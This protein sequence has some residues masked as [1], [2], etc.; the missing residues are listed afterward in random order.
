MNER[1]HSLIIRRFYLLAA[2]A[3][4]ISV[5]GTGT[6]QSIDQSNPTP[7]TSNELI[8]AGPK[9]TNQQYFYS[10]TGGPGEVS[11]TLSVKAKSYSTFVGIKVFDAELNTLASHN[12]SA[13]SSSPGLAK[14][15]FDVGESQTLVLSFTSD[16]NLA[17]CKLKFEG[18]VEFAAGQSSSTSTP[19]EPVSSETSSPAET[20]VQTET[21]STTVEQTSTTGKLGKNKTFINS[22][23]D[24]AG[25]RFNIPAN[26][27]LRIEMKDGSV[28]EI[29][30]TQVKKIQVKQ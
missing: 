9:K 12:M 26:G 29:D 28:Q 27:K 7:I 30:L 16:T 18:T 20:P 21:P 11:I 1:S 23:L 17:E 6:A 2:V 15:K 25:Q 8:I 24:A 19:S 5:A 10:F 4:L 22:I 3:F 13:D 14:K